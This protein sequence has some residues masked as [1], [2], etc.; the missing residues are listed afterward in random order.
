M[1]VGAS[2]FALLASCDRGETPV[3]SVDDPR[4]RT[5]E[6][7][8]TPTTVLEMQLDWQQQAALDPA[9]AVPADGQR[10]DLAG[11]TRVGK[12]IVLLRLRQAVGPQ[13]ELGDRAEWSYAVDCRTTQARLLGAGVGIGRG[14]PSTAAVPGTPAPPAAGD[15]A[16]MFAL[17]CGKR[18]QCEL[19]QRNNPCERARAAVVADMPSPAGRP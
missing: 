12:D 6:L 2:L 10:L 9:F 15:R 3:H 1:I 13:V 4:L 11:A 14:L 16:R 17:V 19:R 7:S 5:G 18:Q 8:S